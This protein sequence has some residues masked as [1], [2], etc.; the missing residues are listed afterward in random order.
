MPTLFL[1][2]I[3]VSLTISRPAVDTNYVQTKTN[4][5]GRHITHYEQR[6][7]SIFSRPV[8]GLAHSFT[9]D[10]SVRRSL[11]QR[12]RTEQIWFTLHALESYVYISFYNDYY[13]LRESVKL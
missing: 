10:P 7:S 3:D 11:A 5:T 13:S 9:F 8:K 6:L 12:S 2:F 4:S 1:S